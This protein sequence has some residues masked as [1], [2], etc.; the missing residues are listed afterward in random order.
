MTEHANIA[1]AFVAAQAQ[2]THVVATREGQARAAKFTYADL[3]DL[4]E[5]A[6]P[7]LQMHGLAF[8]THNGRAAGGVTAETV[9]IHTSGESM[10]TGATFVG[11]PDEAGGQAF[12]SA[13][14][15]ARRYSLLAALGVAAD[16]DD[17]AAAMRAQAAKV[18]RA[19]ELAKAPRF[20]KEQRDVI[21]TIVKH[22]TGN[23]PDL[24]D[25]LAEDFTKYLNRAVELAVKN[26]ALNTDDAPHVTSAAMALDADALTDLL[27]GKTLA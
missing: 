21:T 3:S 9:F 7:I 25:V 8:Q 16:D 19:Q 20:G 2:F 5:M 1:A 10:R 11:V 6:K 14:T 18:E 13:Y 17:G 26:G 22:A 27:T 4:I 15:Y 12:G 24:A 23:T